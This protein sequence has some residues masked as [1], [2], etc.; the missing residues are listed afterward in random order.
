MLSFVLLSIGLAVVVWAGLYFMQRAGAM[1][2]RTTSML[3]AVG[4]LGW[5]LA[6]LPKAAIVLPYMNWAGI[7]LDGGG[8]SLD[9]IMLQ[10][11]GFLLVGALAAGIFEEL[12]KPVGLLVVRR[13]PRHL[14]AGAVIGAGAGLLEAV[15]FVAAAALTSDFQAT[16]PLERLT[17]IAFHGALTALLVTGFRRGQALWVI[18]PIALHVAADWFIPWLQLTGAV[19]PVGALGVFGALTLISVLLAVGLYREMNG[20]DATDVGMPGESVS[21]EVRV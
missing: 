10:Q 19:G 8:Q 5:L 1:T 13:L 15:N 17:A 18:A 16:I 7:P 6:K 12:F 3:L 14:I 11:P 20:I 21:V 4:A 9:E 2:T